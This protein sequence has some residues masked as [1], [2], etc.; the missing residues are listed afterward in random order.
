MTAPRQ[1]Y[2]LPAL[3]AL[4]RPHVG[5][6]PCCCMSDP[7]PSLTPG[8]GEQLVLTDQ[9][10]NVVDHRAPASCASKPLFVLQGDAQILD[11]QTIQM[12]KGPVQ[13]QRLCLR[14]SVLV[15]LHSWDSRSLVTLVF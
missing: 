11:S 5:R 2:W 7:S 6:V 15:I 3:P 1:C 4:G 12:F 10:E 8:T 9:E 13:Q 14:N